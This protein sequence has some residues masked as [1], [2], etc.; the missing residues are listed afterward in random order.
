MEKLLLDQI[1]RW[2]S[3]QQEKKLTQVQDIVSRQYAHQKIKL[4][5]ASTA[6]VDAAISARY[7]D[8]RH[9]RGKIA[10]HA[11]WA[12]DLYCKSILSPLTTIK[13]GI[14]GYAAVSID[15]D[16]V[17]PFGEWN[18]WRANLDPDCPTLKTLKKLQFYRI[19]PHNAMFDRVPHEH[20]TIVSMALIAHYDEQYKAH[21]QAIM[22]QMTQQPG[23]PGLVPTTDK[24][25]QDVRT[26]SY[27]GDTSGM[28][29]GMEE[30]TD[31][32]LA[33]NALKRALR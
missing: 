8:L 32:Q 10:I 9:A 13:P 15:L 33:N 29:E 19:S 12:Y 24:V 22:S 17:E 30:Q 1:Q 25:L 6:L 28:S 27:N 21:F 23:Q 26:T 7:I 11:E 4:T 20:A 2:K 31:D 16:T 18:L 5:A 14:K 3:E